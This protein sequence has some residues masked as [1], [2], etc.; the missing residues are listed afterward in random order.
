MR[1]ITSTTRILARL[2]A[3]LLLM[4]GAIT[5][6]P[7]GN[8]PPASGQLARSGGATPA[9]CTA[10]LAFDVRWPQINLDFPGQPLFN[11]GNND[12]IAD[13]LQVGHAKLPSLA[14][15]L[16][17]LA[18]EA[19]SDFQSGL[20]TL[21]TDAQTL[22]NE[23][24]SATAAQSTQEVGPI[25][26]AASVVQRS[27]KT[28]DCRAKVKDLSSAAASST[29]QSGTDSLGSSRQG[30][31]FL[32]VAFFLLLNFPLIRRVWRHRRRSTLNNEGTRFIGNLRRWKIQTTK[33]RVL[34]VQR[35]SIKSTSRTYEPDG[36]VSVKTTTTVR[37]TIRLGLSDGSQTDMTLVNFLASPTIGDV[38]TTCVAHKRS[39][40]V[41][42]ALLN[43]VTDASVVRAQNLYSLR[44]GGTIRQTIFFLGLIF[45]SLISIVVA[46]FSGASWLLTVWIGL[47]IIF[48]LE[49][50]R[51]A[52]TDLLPLWRRANAEVEPLRA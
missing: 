29:N 8:A 32:A 16:A 18:S 11:D 25:E 5:L 20:R 7:F 46:V 27:L 40:A 1:L 47:I 42:F 44:G 17:V 24:A 31:M 41:T 38:V 23:P 37:E 4:L 21:A 34:N 19:P 10:V 28:Q 26:R 12:G 22:A 3:T 6:G 15:D 39:R 51:G 50:R 9:F 2:V 45:G 35:Q 33:G 36:H 30:V 52:S 49:S 14:S 43:H 13:L 48:A